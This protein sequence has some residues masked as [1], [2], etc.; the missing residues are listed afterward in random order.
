MPSL[1]PK[2]IGAAFLCTDIIR[3]VSNKISVIGIF[4][5]D[6]VIDDFPAKFRFALYVE[7]YPSSEKSQ[8]DFRI[9][10]GEQ[11]LVE[12]KGEAGGPMGDM[13]PIMLS[14]L[15][16]ELMP[17]TSFK[18]EVRVSNDR[19]FAMV[20]KKIVLGKVEKLYPAPPA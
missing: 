4:T 20:D 7:V 11:E 9:K 18:V 17:N 15:E 13:I 6:I 12:I 2:S 8:V 3:D 10:I 16:A 5:H 14:N 1:R 19:W